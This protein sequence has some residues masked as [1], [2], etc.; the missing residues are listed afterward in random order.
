MKNKRAYTATEK[1]LMISPS[2]M[3]PIANLVRR[4]SYADALAILDATPKKGSKLIKKAIM[5]AAANAVYSQNGQLDEES[6]F[7]SEIQITEGPRLKRVWPRSQGRRDILLK[8]MSHIFVAVD[9][10]EAK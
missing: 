2:K 8:R 10:G 9:E 5:S 7:V 3:R 4:K 1:F 6:L